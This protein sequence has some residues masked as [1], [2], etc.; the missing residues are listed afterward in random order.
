[1]EVNTMPRNPAKTPCSV[2]GC[3]AWAIRGSDP[4]LCSP[5]RTRAARSKHSIAA[6]NEQGVAARNEQGVTACSEHSMAA[7]TDVSAGRPNPLPGF[8]TGDK[9]ITSYLD[10]DRVLLLLDAGEYVGDAPAR[11]QTLATAIRAE[12]A[13]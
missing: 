4:P 6:C 8:L 2:D 13:K 9:R 3:R 7:W 10:P 5:H 12:L 1:M 11:A